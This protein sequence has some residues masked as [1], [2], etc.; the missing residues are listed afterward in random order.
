MSRDRHLVFAYPIIVNKR[1]TFTSS[2]P[3]R[4]SFADDTAAAKLES[5]RGF[6]PDVGQGN[7]RR[8]HLR[9]GR[10]TSASCHAAA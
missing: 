10:N 6:G 1:I 4:Q 9:F 7:I 5:T 2:S 8:H 3:K